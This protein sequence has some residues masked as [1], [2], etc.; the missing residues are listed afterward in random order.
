[1]DGKTSAVRKLNLLRRT[2]MLEIF[3]VGFATAVFMLYEAVAVN[4]GAIG[5]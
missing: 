3:E 2:S 4:D 1:M 5:G